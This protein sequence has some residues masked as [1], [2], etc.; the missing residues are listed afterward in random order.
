MNDMNQQNNT[1]RLD[2]KLKFVQYDIVSQGFGQLAIQNAK[3][4][5]ARGL[6][7]VNEFDDI[8]DS[9]LHEN[10]YHVDEFEVAD[11]DLKAIDTNDDADDVLFDMG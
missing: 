5:L 1:T 9:S 4:R 8:L 6:R 11:K 7:D 10:S 2:K 3:E